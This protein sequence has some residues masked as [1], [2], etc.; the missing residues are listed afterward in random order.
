MKQQILEALKN[1]NFP[2]LKFLYSPDALLQ[3][4]EILEEL[5]EQEKADF[6]AKLEIPDIEITF[7]TFQDFSL[8]DYYFGL[9]EHYQGVHSDDVIRKIIE[10]FEPKY[11][12]FGNEIA[13]S[14][15]YYDM[16]KICI[17]NFD[18]DAE[19]TRILT[20]SI[21]AFEVRGI[22]LDK[23]KQSE[24]K[25]ISKKLSELS[26]KFSNNVVD[27][28]KEFEYIIR[29]E[30]SISQMPEDDKQAAKDRAQKDKVEWYL[31]DSSQGAY[32]SI[33]KYCSDSS[34]R[35]HFYEFRHKV[36]TSG[37]HDNTPLILEILEL[38]NRKAELLGFK[39]YGELSLKFKMAESPEQIIEL[40]SD[41]SQKARPKSQAEL[42]EISEYFKLDELNIWDLSYYANILRKE[43]YELDD[44]EL[45]KYFDF[46]AV[47]KWMFEIVNRLYGIEM[48][49]LDTKSYHDDVEIYEVS[50]NGEFLSYFFTDY[51]YNELKRP[52]AWANIVR[53][54]FQENK[55]ITLNVCNFQKSEN[56]PTLLTLS[57]V[58][59]MFH[60]F[61][62]ATHEMLSRSKYS[63]VG[64]NRG[65][66][67]SQ[68]I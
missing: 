29:D 11:I 16:L 9:L 63:G 20:K 58:E 65:C 46:E 39:N 2:D 22:A 14:K 57:D 67:S 4:P 62:H 35:K 59:T 23:E 8:L 50:R 28:K 64:I 31:F 15:R 55:K 25:G 66:L 6:I 3:A 38:R 26:Q 44:R 21:E 48:K 37:E 51:F 42:D 41:I 33:M 43:K 19:Q 61:G 24:L 17:N 45:K 5:L 7:E 34:V 49:K 60:E 12:D 10:D 52:G 54:T 53:E 36:A 30:S 68:N 18:L 13:Y 56:R 27:S 1:P 47:L 32:M 40:F